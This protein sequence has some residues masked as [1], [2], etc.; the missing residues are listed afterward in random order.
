MSAPLAAGYDRLLVDLDGTAYAGAVAI[1]G[2][3]APAGPSPT[4]T[5]RVSAMRWN[6]GSA[7]IT[8]NRA[9]ARRP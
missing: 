5:T 3:A 7:R 2:A 4:T 8:T 9:R 6:S 1:P